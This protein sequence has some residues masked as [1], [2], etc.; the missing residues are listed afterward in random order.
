[1]RIYNSLFFL[2]GLSAV[3]TANPGDTTFVTVHN[4]VDMTWYGNYDQTG[5]FPA[6]GTEY[7]KV[8]LHYTMGCA[9]GGCSDWDYTTQIFLMN[10][11]GIMDSTVVSI[12]TVNMDTTWNVFEVLQPLE[13][14]RVITPYGGSLSNSWTRNFVFDVTDFAH[15][16]HDNV[17]IRAH[18][19]G[20]S[21]GFSATLNFHFIEGTPPRD[22]L[23]VY[24]I[25]RDGATYDNSANFENNYFNT[26]SIDV[27]AGAAGGRIFSTIT[28]HGFDNNV[29][30][31]E[32]CSKNYSVKVNSQTLGSRT[33]W[34]DDCGMNPLFPQAGTWLYDRAGWCPGDKGITHELEVG[35]LLQAGAVN[36][37]NFDMDSY[38]WSGNQAPSYTVD[39]RLVVYGAPNFN[40]DAYLLDVIAP[41]N[42]FEYSR[43][44]PVCAKPVVLVQNTGANTLT[45]IT[46]RYNV[47]GAAQCEYTWTGSL[48]F[49]EQ[50]KI[51]LPNLS[52]ENAD[53][54]NPLFHVK[55][56]QINGG[57]DEYGLNN[58]AHSAFALPAV[59]NYDTVYVE[60]KTNNYGTETGYQL[61]D[62][63]GNVVAQRVASSLAANTTYLDAI[64][65][66]DGC[67]ML[68][69]TDSGKDGLSF[70]ADAAAG[71]GTFRLLR[72]QAP[73]GYLPLRSFGADF[74]TALY[75]PF[76]AGASKDAISNN[77]TVGCDLTGVKE[78]QSSQQ[79]ASMVYPN[80]NAGI[81]NIELSLPQTEELHLQVF[82][83]TGRC[84]QT[85]VYN[86]VKN[87]TLQVQ[88]PNIPVGMYWVKMNTSTQRWTHTVVVT[89]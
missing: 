53:L 5:T 58:E 11:T 56:H 32:F 86:S 9:T 18:Y 2:L 49:L 84:L 12:D 70:W 28:G 24:N 60:L 20:W 67:Y 82:D 52:W 13:L 27:P 8:W 69:V 51:E 33:I 21:S 22:I 68:K 39:A 81:F 78:V 4:Q 37:F 61:L 46:L 45:S 47:E 38:T 73:F 41:S 23:G 83:A 36:T 62:G 43:L 19:S 76:I 50:V 74:G 29:G 55:I 35:N 89:K 6:A 66:P 80:P 40:N 48:A 71:A 10:P 79:L 17:L 14:G 75:Y 59:H 57:A 87:E 26:K 34:R 3:A 16:L 72:K 44:N 42:N 15:L 54:V 88:L 25:Y 65:V 64:A 77:I 85:Q 63:N 7:R 31:A 1:M 30:C